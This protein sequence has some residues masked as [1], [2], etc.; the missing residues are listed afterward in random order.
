M[1][2]HNVVKFKYGNNIIKLENGFIARQSTSSVIASMDDTVVIVTLVCDSEIKIDQKFLPLSVYYQEKFYSIGKIPG[3]FFRREGRSS[4][5]EIIISRLIDRSIR[6]LF[7]D[8]LLNDIQITINVVSVNPQVS[9]DIISIIGV[10][11]ALSISGIPDIIP[12]SVARIGYV[13]NNY[14][15]NPSIN[16]INISKLNLVIAGTNDAIFMIDCSSKNLEEKYIINGIDFACNNFSVVLDNINIF[17]DKVSKK[18]LDKNC[19]DYLYDTLPFDIDNYIYNFCINDLNKIY[20]KKYNKRK[21][22]NNLNNIEKK[23]FLL[24]EKNNKNINNNLVIKKINEI[25]K[26]IIINK[27]LNEGKRIDGRSLKDI[28][29][30]DIKVGFLPNRVHGS[31][32]FTRGE[33]QALVTITLGTSR[34]AQSFD[35]IFLGERLDNFIFHYNFPPYSV[36]EIGNIGIPKRREVGHGYLAK[37]G[38]IPI[39]PNKNNF[40]YTIRIVSDILESNGSSSMASVCGASLALM[41]AGVPIKYHVAGIA[42]GL[43]KFKDK[44]FIISDIISDED[45]LGDMDFKIIGTEL[46]ITALQ[47]DMKVKGIFCDDIFNSLEKSKES[48]LY[49]IQ[50]MNNFIKKPRYYIS[51]YAPRIHKFKININKIKDVIGKGG[52]VIKYLTDKYNCFIEI[53]NDGIVNIISSNK[54]NI[55]DVVYKINKII[56][57]IKIGYTYSVLIKKIFSFGLIVYFFNKKEGLVYIPKNF[58]KNKNNNIFSF[59][60]IGQYINAKVLSINNYGKIKLILKDNFNKCK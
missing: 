19:F 45:K 5:T 48:R 44:K 36:G 15:L 26:K 43:I 3:S 49:I 41:D 28:R 60:K 31:S 57:D 50:K 17:L 12:I 7:N 8:K 22:I 11:A 55:D 56:E 25:K 39:L 33:T 2:E 40:P 29:D 38:I 34:D 9:T 4:D 47:M 35:D 54:K 27:L 21:L 16:E 20:S 18:N 10:S 1:L 59:F 42:M 13:N 53:N 14:I 51:D 32:L 58:F 23:L 37:K 6:P 30:I 24:L 46:G 52:N